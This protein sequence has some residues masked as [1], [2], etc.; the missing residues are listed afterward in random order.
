M[1]TKLLRNQKGTILNRRFYA[2]FQNYLMGR[3]FLIVTDHRASTC[4]YSFKEPDG[5]IARCLEKLGHFQFEIK[6]EAGKII[7]HAD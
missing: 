1:T 6:H 4:L 7:P 2:F 5:M 3:Q